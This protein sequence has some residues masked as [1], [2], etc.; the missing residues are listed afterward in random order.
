MR[1]LSALLRATIAAGGLTV[2]SVVGLALPASAS[3]IGPLH[4]VPGAF[5][6]GPASTLSCPPGQAVATD[7]C[8]MVGAARA[9][10]NLSNYV[11]I[12][13]VMPVIDGVPG[14]P[15][16]M[17]GRDY[18]VSIDCVSQTT[19]VALGGVGG[20]LAML[21][22]DLGKVTKTVAVPLAKSW[23]GLA[24]PSANTCVA[25]G[26]STSKHGI[27]VTWDGKLAQDV[28]AG[29]S[30][31]NAVSCSSATACV[32][33]GEQG[34][35]LKFSQYKGLFV[36]VNGTSVGPAQVASGTAD[37]VGV[38]CN[39]GPSVCEAN[40]EAVVGAHGFV[41]VR[42]TISGGKATTAKLPATSP[43][44]PAICPA[45]GRCLQFGTVSVAGSG[46]HGFIASVTGGHF[47]APAA[48]SGTGQVLGVSCSGPGSCEAVAT[49]L[50]GAAGDLS[51]ATF[52]FT[53]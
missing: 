46:Q 41:P 24:C 20:T 51:L 12:Y 47:G 36:S 38:A 26:T 3:V 19:C 9:G 45:A 5:S 40:G 50:H 18:A 49:V 15:F 43:V 6:A 17:P 31:M 10:T 21:W 42:T 29:S 28:V 25:V 22:F 8:W 48:I 34:T 11:N 52:T 4:D 1:S 27:I 33:V 16:A 32:A 7:T 39:W 23:N 44:G 37:L 35:G 53:S 14:G 2:V 13:E 30:E